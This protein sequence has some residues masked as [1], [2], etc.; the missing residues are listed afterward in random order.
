M[1]VL[2][3]SHLEPGVLGEGGQGVDREDLRGLHCG[4]LGFGRIVA[5]D[6]EAPNTFVNLV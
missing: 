5:S 3:V 1:V 2:R 4:D 6:I